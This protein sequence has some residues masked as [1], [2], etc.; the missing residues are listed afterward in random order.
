MCLETG[1]TVESSLLLDEASLFEGTFAQGV[2]TDKV[3]R[4]PGLVHCHYVL[5]TEGK[6][7]QRLEGRHKSFKKFEHTEWVES[8]I[9]RKES[10]RR[11]VDSEGSHDHA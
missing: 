3:I 1:F 5:T 10:S 6:R 11:R 7:Q 9:R 8:S 4:T 2:S